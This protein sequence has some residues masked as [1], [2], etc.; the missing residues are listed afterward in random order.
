[1]KQAKRIISIIII[2]TLLM[3]FI[4]PILSIVRADTINK[5][6]SLGANLT[7]QQ[8][9]QILDYMDVNKD[10]VHLIKTTIQEE[11][12]YLKDTPAIEHIGNKTMSSAYVERLNEGDG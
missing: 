3:T 4:F 8:Q 1:M 5:V 11:A 2:A 6:V 9:D 12:E 10:E 7:Q